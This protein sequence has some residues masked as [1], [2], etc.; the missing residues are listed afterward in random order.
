MGG[1]GRSAREEIETGVCMLPC[2]KIGID[3]WRPLFSFFFP[4]FAV[5]IISIHWSLVR[6]C[7]RV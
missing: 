2:C 4:T 6:G 7:M 1:E 5:G 3:G